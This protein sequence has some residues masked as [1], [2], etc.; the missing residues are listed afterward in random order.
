MLKVYDLMKYIEEIA[1]S[2]KALSFDN[3]GLMTGSRDKE[4]RG[5]LCPDLTRKLFMKR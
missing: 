4:V 5:I 3:V 1:P 2:E